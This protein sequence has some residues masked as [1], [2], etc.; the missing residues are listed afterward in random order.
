[1]STSTTITYVA[2]VPQPTGD[3][4]LRAQ[5]GGTTTG[6][7]FVT[8]NWTASGVGYAAP[9]ASATVGGTSTNFVWN[10][11]ADIG[12]GESSID[13]NNDNLVKGLDLDS[14]SLL[15]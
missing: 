4:S 2:D 8:V 13:W 11:G 15:D 5:I 6:D 3:Y 14:W 9:A 7:D 10:D 12:V 1:M